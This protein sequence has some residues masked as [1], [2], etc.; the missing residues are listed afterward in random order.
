MF[1]TQSSLA[2]HMLYISNF[3]VNSICSIIYITFSIQLTIP[4]SLLGLVHLPFIQLWSGFLLGIGR[5]HF[6]HGMYQQRDRVWL[7]CEWVSYDLVFL[8]LRDL[9]VLYFLSF[10]HFKKFGFRML[11]YFLV[12]SD[13]FLSKFQK[14]SWLTT[15]KISCL[16]P[17]AAFTCDSI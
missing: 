8:T 6:W 17:Y 12:I 7:E 10:R 16:S 14:T 11:F 13:I 1:S 9:V 3:I 2:V 4:L 15:N 5:V